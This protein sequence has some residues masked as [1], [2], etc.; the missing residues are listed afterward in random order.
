MPLI[1]PS[2]PGNSFLLYKLLL[3]PLN[4]A[5]TQSSGPSPALLGELQRLGAGAIMGLAMP[6]SISGAPH[7]MA[8]TGMGDAADAEA[9]QRVVQSVSTWIAHGAVTGCSP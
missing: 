1:D 5:H 4:H 8:R 3:H 6:I 7:G 9:S 2:N